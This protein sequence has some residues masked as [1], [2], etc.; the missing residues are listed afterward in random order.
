MNKDVIYID[1]ED[2]ITAIIGRIKDSKEKIV[3]LVP[4]KRIG[5]LQSAVNLRLLTR[6]ADSTNKKLVLI[7]NNKALIALS[8][9][10]RIPIAKNL[11][12]KPE[13]AEISA[14]DVD[15]GDDVIYGNQ[16]P[17][18]DLERTVDKPS[19]SSEKEII[20]AHKIKKESIESEMAEIDIDGD[21]EKADF[22]IK[23]NSADQPDLFVKVKKL[24]RNP[25]FLIFH[26]LE[27]NLSSV[28]AAE[29][30]L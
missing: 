11:Q 1:T 25:K 21:Q 3:A 14:L 28:S 13:F 18:G 8:A 20:P 9:T 30:C 24:K 19:G 22:V 5:V 26:S 15:D 10:A 29:F 23:D 2:D 12:S 6:I 27:K 7:T 4:P 17:V 16:L